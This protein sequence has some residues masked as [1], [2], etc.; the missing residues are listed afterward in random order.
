MTVKKFSLFFILLL[1]ALPAPAKQ[2]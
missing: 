1:L 2:F